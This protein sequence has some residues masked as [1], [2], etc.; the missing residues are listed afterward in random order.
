MSSKTS[1]VELADQL[2]TVVLEVRAFG[3]ANS[4]YLTRLETEIRNKGWRLGTKRRDKIVS[5]LQQ[6]QTQI[7]SLVMRLE[8]VLNGFGRVALHEKRILRKYW[9]EADD[10]RQLFS[11][12]SIQVERLLG[13]VPAFSQPART[14]SL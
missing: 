2:V 12:G 4:P 6:R 10:V 11:Q 3:E 7:Q 14:G 9:Q 13:P 5:E 1:P 8:S